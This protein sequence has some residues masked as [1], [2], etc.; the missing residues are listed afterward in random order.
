MTKY[1]K[2]IGTV[3]GGVLAVLM[4]TCVA[5][6]AADAAPGPGNA[7]CHVDAVKAM[8]PHN[9][10]GTPTDIV[11]K[12]SIKCTADIDSLYIDVELQR[13]EGGSWKRVAGGHNEATKPTAGT[14]LVAR[15][16][17]TCA[18]GEYR[19]AARGGGVYGGVPSQSSAW[20]YSDTVVNP[21]GK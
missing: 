1:A 16:A 20:K 7:N 19:T 18:D 6:P 14:K 12:G 2:N 10:K 5:L 8:N 15:G 21:C 17:T 13:K 9:S 4:T 3:A 11:G